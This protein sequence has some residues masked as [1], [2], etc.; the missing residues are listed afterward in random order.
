MDMT[1]P[2]KEFIGIPFPV[3]VT[4]NASRA[5]E[6]NFRGDVYSLLFNKACQGTQ[7]LR[8]AP[9]NLGRTGF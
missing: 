9:H 2:E 7:H 3:A 4:H 1:I 8:A 6:K 5:Y